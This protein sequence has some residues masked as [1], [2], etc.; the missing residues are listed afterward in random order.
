MMASLKKS[1]EAEIEVKD[2]VYQ[3][4]EIVFPGASLEVRDAIRRAVYYTEK[5]KVFNRSNE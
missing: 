3:G 5:W 4:V 1:Q 2:T